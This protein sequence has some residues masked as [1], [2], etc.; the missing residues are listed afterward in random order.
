MSVWVNEHREEERKGER[1]GLEIE[2]IRIGRVGLV[3]AN[4]SFL[5]LRDWKIPRANNCH[6][7]VLNQWRDYGVHPSITISPQV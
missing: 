2:Y 1:E 6:I 4:K 3:T 7:G 5:T